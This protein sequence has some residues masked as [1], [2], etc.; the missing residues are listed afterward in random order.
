MMMVTFCKNVMC[1]CGEEINYV[2]ACVGNHFFTLHFSF[3]VA[4][5]I[6]DTHKM[7]HKVNVPAHPHT[8]SYFNITYYVPS[9]SA[10]ASPSSS[11]A[12]LDCSKKVE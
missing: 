12:K 11:C 2:C 6:D 7:L 8:S 9:I 5:N 3:E 10:Y 1:W 4:F